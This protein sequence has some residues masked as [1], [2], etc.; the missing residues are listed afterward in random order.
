ML[1]VSQRPRI[2]RGRKPCFIMKI[3]IREIDFSHQLQRE[4]LIGGQVVKYWQGEHTF[5]VLLR[6]PK[7]HFYTQNNSEY[8]YTCYQPQPLG[9][10]DKVLTHVFSYNGTKKQVINKAS[11]LHY[12]E[13]L[14]HE[15]KKSK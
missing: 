2:A 4:L 5:T 13:E 9:R 15:L 7:G 3:D 12:D 11:E 10:K 8:E 1:C 14:Y 6:L